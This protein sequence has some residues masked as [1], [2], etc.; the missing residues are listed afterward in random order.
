MALAGGWDKRDNSEVIIPFCGI[1]GMDR[2]AE[3]STFVTIAD[4]GS[5]AAAARRLRISPQAATRAIA[6]L[7]DR[8]GTQLLHRTTRAV[9]LT[10]EGSAYLGRARTVLAEMNDADQMLAGAQ[11]RPQGTLNVTASVMLGRMHVLPIVGALLKAHPELSVR[12]LLIDRIVQLAEEGI[13]VAVRIDHLEDSALRAVPVGEVRR[14]FVASPAYLKA[15]GVPYEPADLRAHDVI[16]FTGLGSGDELRFGPRGKTGVK[17]RPR[18]IVNSGDASIAA[19]EAGLGIARALSYQVSKAVKAGRLKTVL[20]A[21][22]PPAIPISLVFQA[23]RAASPNVR[24]F[25]DAAKAHFKR[26]RDGKSLSA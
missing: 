26:A 19:A 18:L 21:H 15:R 14:V 5:F 16:A 2:F 20:D 1:I 13:D 11:S 24:A 7:E 3:L 10:D 12:L 22:A 9:R 17:V 25:I 23:A 8:L 4:E 6:A